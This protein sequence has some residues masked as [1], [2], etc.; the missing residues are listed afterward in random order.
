[1]SINKAANRQNIRV[2]IL[3]KIILAIIGFVTIIIAYF[4]GTIKGGGLKKPF[5]SENKYI[6]RRIKKYEK[7]FDKYSDSEFVDILNNTDD[8]LST[9]SN[10]KAKLT[11]LLQR[12]RM[13]ADRR[14]NN[15]AD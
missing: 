5:E 8:I 7:E 4:V 2:G 15:E 6:N 13:E 14:R 12:R 1:M 9:I 3:E 10:G 11:N